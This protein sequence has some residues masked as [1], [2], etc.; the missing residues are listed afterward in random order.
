[1]QPNAADNFLPT[2][3]PRVIENAYSE[4]QHQR[5]LGVVRRHGPWQLILAENFKTPEEVIATTSG[6]LPEGI[7]LTWD[8]ILTPVFRGYL[9]RQ[10]VCFYPELED[11]P[12]R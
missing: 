4:D 12:V 2:A 8:M 7:Q 5:L 3:P 6:K 1:M 11:C 10:G 9:A